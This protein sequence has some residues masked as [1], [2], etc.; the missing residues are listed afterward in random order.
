MNLNGKTFID[1][2]RL[3]EQDVNVNFLFLTWEATFTFVK[4]AAEKNSRILP[5]KSSKLDDVMQ[6]LWTLNLSKQLVRF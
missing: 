4:Q 6:S 2:I 1:F 3:T 5:H